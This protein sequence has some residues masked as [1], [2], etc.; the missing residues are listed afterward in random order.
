[1]KQ[2]NYKKLHSDK[3]IKT[4]EELH[5]RISE[6]FPNAGL[7]GVCEELLRISKQSE[8]RI[9]KLE[10]RDYKLYGMIITLFIFG[11]LLIRY[12]VPIHIPQTFNSSINVKD[13]SD[14][15]QLLGS[16]SE[17]LTLMGLIA[18]FV[19]TFENR[20]KK[21]RALKALYELRSIA[22]VIDMHQLTKDPNK[23]LKNIIATKSSPKME[24]DA[25]AL[26]RYL[27]YCT[28]MLSL[29]GK[30]AALYGESLRD[31]DSIAMVNDIED[32][33]TGLSRK[34]WQKIMLL[35]TF[36]EKIL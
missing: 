12:L 16:A 8:K 20:I 4:I 32:L 10:E 9:E 6:R 27:N 25:N 22:H 5:A 13:W 7:V 15:I 19:M 36:S 29:T 26:I 14:I 28:E 3:I 11:V 31:G 34:I 33:T 2:Q 17:A 35:N 23:I 18:L 30:I 21:N 24:L 1:M